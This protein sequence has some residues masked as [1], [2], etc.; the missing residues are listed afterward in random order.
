MQNNAKS[1]SYFVTLM[2]KTHVCSCTNTRE[3]TTKNIMRLKTEM[4]KNDTH[5]NNHNRTV[6]RADFVNILKINNNKNKR[7][8]YLSLHLQN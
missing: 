6:H 5:M 8:N 1:T 2:S 4:K 7:I 3:K